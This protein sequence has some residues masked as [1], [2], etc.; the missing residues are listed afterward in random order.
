MG[1]SEQNGIWSQQ[2]SIYEGGMKNAFGSAFGIGQSNNFI[3]ACNIKADLPQ[4]LPLGIPL[5]PYFDFGYFDNA[6]PI[7]SE[8][9]FKDQFLWS[10]GLMLEFFNGK[11]GVYF[12]LVN[13]ENM[14]TPYAEKDNYWG[15]VTFNLELNKLNPWKLINEIEF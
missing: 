10:G 15:K 11:M 4:R 5:K 7:G 8:D 13:S 14:K 3:F 12:P 1:R 2:I 6:T 9:S